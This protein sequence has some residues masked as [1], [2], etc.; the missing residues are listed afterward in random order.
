MFSESSVVSF[1]DR[2][3]L[4]RKLRAELD[5]IAEEYQHAKQNY[6]AALELQ[7]KPWFGQSATANQNVQ[8]ALLDVT[9][10][11]N[12]YVALLRAFADLILEGKGLTENTGMQGGFLADHTDGRMDVTGLW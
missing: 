6:E 10:I 12:R 7:T 3:T 8:M 9:G 5:A 11:R 2:G 1:S 4:E